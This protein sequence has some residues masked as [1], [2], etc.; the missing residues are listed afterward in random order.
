MV[1][2]WD[3]IRDAQGGILGVLCLFATGCLTEDVM[4]GGVG[5]FILTCLEF[6]FRAVSA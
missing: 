4:D 2:G 6:C 1:M 3:V 5:L